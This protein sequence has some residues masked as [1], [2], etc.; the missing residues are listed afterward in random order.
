MIKRYCDICGK[1]VAETTKYMLPFQCRKS[2]TDAAGH[3]IKHYN[4]IEP[5]EKD[6]CNK[7]E[8]KIFRTIKYYM[9]LAEK[10]IPFS[11]PT[12]GGYIVEV[13][14]KKEVDLDEI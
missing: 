13:N 9:P 7:C 5:A 10:Q 11:Y 4:V 6:V 3:V 2:A 1:E 14:Y 12:E 8:S